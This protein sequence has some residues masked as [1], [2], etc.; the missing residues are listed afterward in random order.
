MK[1]IKF[2]LI[3][4]AA[5][6]VGNATAQNYTIDWY[7]VAGGSGAST[8]GQYSLSGTIGQ[9]DAGGPMTGGSFSLTGGF[10]SLF[11]VQTPGASTLFI[12]K[13][14][15]NAVLYWSASA[16]GYHL[17][18]NGSPANS[19]GWGT[20]PGIPVTVGGFNYVTNGITPG[21]KFYRLRSP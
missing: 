12:M 11:A 4:S 15:N 14:G 17:E 1:L 5:W 21:N 2:V 9:Y 18:S 19:G 8:N 13:S 3:L 20:V 6:L 16:T 10:W 7:K